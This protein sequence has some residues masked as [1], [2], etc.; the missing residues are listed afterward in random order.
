MITYIIV[1]NIKQ[2][3]GPWAAWLLRLRGRPVQVPCKEITHRG[4]HINKLDKWLA[5]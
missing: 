4:C 2:G 3:L 5:I 1:Y